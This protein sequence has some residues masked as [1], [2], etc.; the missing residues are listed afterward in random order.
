VLWAIGTRFDAARDLTIVNDWSGPGGILPSNWTYFADGTRA[1]RTSS[2]MIID[3]TKP[4]PPIP[5]PPR[6]TVPG[7]ALA[8]VDLAALD[9]VSLDDPL[10]RSETPAAERS[11]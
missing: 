3:A 11:G 4:V 7:D 6:T 8:G 10:L 5:Y 2:A 9:D 1:P